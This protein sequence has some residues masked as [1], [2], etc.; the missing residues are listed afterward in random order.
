M[1]LSLELIFTNSTAPLKVPSQTYTPPLSSKKQNNPKTK[2]KPQT[3][4]QQVVFKS[5]TLIKT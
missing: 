3:T 4:V 2:T 1:P 5:N